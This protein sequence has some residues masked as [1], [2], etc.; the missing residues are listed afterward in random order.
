MLDTRSF[1]RGENYA[2]KLN[3]NELESRSELAYC[4]ECF[5]RRSVFQLSTMRIFS[6]LSGIAI[7]YIPEASSSSETD[8]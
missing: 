8:P 3:P 7:I 1:Q 2:A 4:K 5:E 6:F